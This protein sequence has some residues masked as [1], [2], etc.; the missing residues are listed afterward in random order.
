MSEL[1]PTPIAAADWRALKALLATVFDTLSDAGVITLMDAGTTQSDGFADCL[2]LFHARGADGAGLHG[3]VFFTKQDANRAKDSALLPIAFWGAPDGSA[4]NMMRVGTLLVRSLR[5]SNLAIQW[6][7]S[8]STRPTWEITADDLK[9]AKD[10]KR[11]EQAASRAVKREREMKVA[12]E[13]AAE[14]FAAKKYSA[15]IKKIKRFES[16]LP[17]VH[18]KKLAF[19]RKRTAK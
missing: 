4:D 12:L 2:E 10:N 14:L 7:E 3:F 17:P 6:D 16:I 15:Y 5:D 13:A 19:A 8:P 1:A 11:A 18:Q 9:L